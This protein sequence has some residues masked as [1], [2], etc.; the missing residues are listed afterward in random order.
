MGVGSV[1]SRGAAAACCSGGAKGELHRLAEK[2][3]LVSVLATFCS[4]FQHANIPT[5]RWLGFFVTR[6]ESHSAH[7]ER[8]VHG[9]NYGDIP[10]FDMIFGT[11]HNP[12][13][14]DGEVGFYE[15]GSK[16]VGDMLLGRLVA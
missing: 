9:R 8:G 5:P 7:H 4:M 11:F 1:K 6:P 2:A 10:I 14:F 12:R 13:T 3:H 15:G 16:R